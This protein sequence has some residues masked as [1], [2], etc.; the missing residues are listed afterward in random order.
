M[1]RTTTIAAV[2]A[3]LAMASGPQAVMAGM[4]YPAYIAS[5]NPVGWWG[6]NEAG[7]ATA[8]ADLS[9]A[10]GAANNG[11]GSNLPATYQGVGAGT[12]T[13]QAGFVSGAG[14]RA[15][16]FDG[17]FDSGAY[18]NSDVAYGSNAVGPI[19][20]YETGFS[21][22]VW[23]KTDVL[24]PD[25]NR[26]FI[27]TREWTLGFASYSGI[28]SIQLTTFAKTDYFSTTQFPADG[29]WHQI[30]LSWDGSTASFFLDGV[31][32]GSQAG[33]A[34][35]RAGKATGYNTLNLGHREI[36]LGTSQHFTGWLDE[37]VIWNRTRSA[38]DF[39]ASYAAAT[40][41]EPAT[42]ALLALG[43]L[44]VLRRRTLTRPG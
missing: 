19:Y 31:D 38:S 34:G 29:Q 25:D 2:A 24:V 5:T 21:V 40:V 22:E 16:Y 36:D 30:G 15:A 11:R 9:G 13:D 35:F 27:G 41:P 8:T 20:R 3:V 14:N 37:A 39:A 44:A 18:A 17:S 12:L 6:M 26:R 32:A 33:A 10:Y 23:V 4:N 28:H 42:L 43:G 7:A 1:R